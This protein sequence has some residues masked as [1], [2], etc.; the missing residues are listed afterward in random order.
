MSVPAHGCPSRPTASRVA[1]SFLGLLQKMDSLAKST[2][3]SP[4]EAP[5]LQ[6][7]PH[8]A[9]EHKERLENAPLLPPRRVHTAPRVQPL[10]PHIPGV[11]NLITLQ[12]RRA[13]GR[14]AHVG[15][16]RCWRQRARVRWSCLGDPH[17]SWLGCSPRREGDCRAPS[18]SAFQR[19]HTENLGSFFCFSHVCSLLE[20]IYPCGSQCYIQEG[21]VLPLS[22]T[23]LL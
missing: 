16:R 14:G 20:L 15:T 7:L 1:P 13:P 19:S 8:S 22:Y 17:T 12:P 4:G 9:G 5:D 6:T 3:P 11:Q 10:S 18:L 21:R 23:R 2:N